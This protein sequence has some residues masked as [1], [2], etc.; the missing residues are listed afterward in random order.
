MA[1]PD[2]T[3]AEAPAQDAAGLHDAYAP[4]AIAARIGAAGVSKVRLPFVSML[5]LSILAGAF[6]AFGAALFIV[7][8]H[9]STLGFGVTRLLGGVAFSLG[10]V[11]VVIAGAELFTGNNLSV[12]ALCDGRV[13]FLELMRNWAVVFA[14]NAV[15]AVATAVMIHMSGVLDADGGALGAYAAAIGTAKAGIPA[16]EA[17]VRGV[18]CNTLVCLA[19][20][21]SFAAHT[22]SGKILA[23]VFPIT[24]F[25]ALGFEHSI[26]NLFFL[27]LA[28]LSGADLGFEAAMH[29]LVPVTLGNILGGSLLVGLVYWIIYRRGD[30]GGYTP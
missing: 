21:L 17:F 16:H 18:L 29:N 13:G 5:T 22:V 9:G 3:D 24:A 6:I 25:V 11:L 19:V 7:A 26:A 20:W 10:L 15:G 30:R 28:A 23:I 2:R 4:A 27:P 12:M 1:Q 14:G 8:T